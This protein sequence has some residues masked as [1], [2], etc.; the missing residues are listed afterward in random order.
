M[1]NKEVLLEAKNICKQFGG[2]IALNNVDFSVDKGEI[3]A[4]IGENGAGKSTLMKICLGSYQADSGDVYFKG[5]LANFRS[6][7]EALQAGISMIHQEISLVPTLNIAQNIWLGQESKFFKGQVLSD[8]IIYEKTKELLDGLNIHLNPYTAVASLSIAQMQLVEIARAISCDSELIIMDEPTSALSEEEIRNLFGIMRSLAAEG[9]SIVFISHKLEE[10]KEIC[11]RMTIMRDGQ[12][13]EVRKVAD[14]TIDEI[15][16]K[17]AG[18]K[19]ESII[20]KKAE[21]SDEVVLECRN[22]V[23]AEGVNDVSFTLHKGEVLGFCGLMGSG[24]TEVARA[25]Y[26]L[27]PL[28][29]GEIYIKGKKETI[30]NPKQAIRKGIGMIT[31]DRLRSGVIHV[32][33][34]RT[35]MSLAYLYKI[36]SKMGVIRKAQEKK[37]VNAQIREIGAK[38]ASPEQTIS[39]LSGGNQ[40]KVII[41]RWLMIKPEILIMDEPT[42]GIDVGAKADVYKIIQD[43]VA[44]DMSVILISSELS[45][46]MGISDRIIVMRDGK[47]G[48]EYAAG[49][50]TQDD[51]MKAAFGA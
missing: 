35:N 16:T 29:S 17:I 4:L 30:K 9:K 3:H 13:V 40:Q 41:G 15:I 42:R 38:V 32:L 48:A 1:E 36:C 18:R 44:A 49:E 8:K 24:R 20:T 39:G 51:L 45:E 25:L 43:L 2:S 14:I 5:K 10:L 28:Q 7:H 22:L 19:V 46:V 6:P 11:D 12:L 21:V 50:A 31:E 23:T 34:V 37:D 47:V 26:G 27:D 33:P